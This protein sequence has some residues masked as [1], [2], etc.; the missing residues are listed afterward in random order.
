MDHTTSVGLESYEFPKFFDLFDGG[1]VKAFPSIVF[2]QE[3]DDGEY[4]IVTNPLVQLIKEGKQIESVKLGA[5]WIDD[6]E[7]CANVTVVVEGKKY[8]FSMWWIGAEGVK[9]LVRAE[10]LTLSAL[11]NLKQYIVTYTC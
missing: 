9:D 10:L 1:N 4:H 5:V 8:G 3:G 6:H 7:E 2:E 11:K